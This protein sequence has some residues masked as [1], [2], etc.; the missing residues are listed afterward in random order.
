MS[1]KDKYTDKDF[2]NAVLDVMKGPSI[3]SKHIHD[4]IHEMRFYMIQDLGEQAAD[5]ILEAW[6]HNFLRP[7]FHDQPYS[8]ESTW[9]LRHPTKDQL[10]FRFPKN[11]DHTATVREFKRQ[12][13]VACSTFE[14][15]NREYGNAIHATGLLGSVTEL[16]GCASRLGELVLQNPQAGEQNPGNVYDKL[17]DTVNYA[18][19]SMMMLVIGNYR[20]E[21]DFLKRYTEDKANG[22]K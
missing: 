1:R 11:W 17:V 16:I 21:P 10:E 18:L 20:G 8:S 2:Q 9:I 13:D 14:Q 7:E 12:F 15:K 22:S 3:K 6:W 4:S 19:I 5:E